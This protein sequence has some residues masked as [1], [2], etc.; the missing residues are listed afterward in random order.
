MQAIATP[1]SGSPEQL[2]SVPGSNVDKDK[3]YDQIAF[4]QALAPGRDRPRRRIRLLRAGLPH[5]RRAA[6]AAE[7]AAK[8]GRSFKDWRTYRMSDHLP[9][10]DRVRH[11]RRRRVPGITRLKSR[12]GAPSRASA[13]SQVA[14]GGTQEHERQQQQAHRHE[15]HDRA[16]DVR[17]SSPAAA[18]RLS[19]SSAAG[20]TAASAGRVACRSGTA[21][22]TR[23]GR[24]PS[25]CTSGMKIG[26][27]ISIMLTWSTKMPRKIRIAIIAGDHAQGGSPC[28]RS[29]A[30]GRWWRPRSTGSARTSSRR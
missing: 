28:R 6:Y 3:H 10:S 4:F 5:G 19:S 11:R 15:G 17:A 1:A 29:P 13:G 7:R 21:R 8:P 20:R 12:R 30:P 23:P 25:A 2:Q 22:R 24:S 27:V 26:S 18:P 16:E 9:M 14:T